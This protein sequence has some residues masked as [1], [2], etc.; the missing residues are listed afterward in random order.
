[1]V[2]YF[3]YRGIIIPV[4]L[5]ALC[6]AAAATVFFVIRNKKKG[7]AK[8]SKKQ[9]LIQGIR[10][11]IDCFDGMFEPVYLVAEG[12][13]K[14]QTAVFAAWNEKVQASEEDNGYKA[15]F[16]KQFGSYESWGKGKKKLK[17]KKANKIYKKKAK[18]LLKLFKKAGIIRAEDIYEIGSETTAE[19][20]NYIGAES[21]EADA[22]YDVLAPYW[23]CGDK[24]VDK[25]VI[26]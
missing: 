10:D 16:Q 12:K 17:V 15:L 18:K 19:K 20:Y 23:S 5:A 26:R 4:I 24:I 1:M 9:I 21:I 11:N 6:G 2:I 7:D 25:G 8:P 13:N 22:N 14:K 3:L